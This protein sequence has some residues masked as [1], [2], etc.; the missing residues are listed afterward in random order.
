MKHFHNS[1]YIIAELF[2]VNPFKK[3]N[4][5]KPNFDLSVRKWSDFD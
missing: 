1:I 3:Y 4:Y 2:V 5:G